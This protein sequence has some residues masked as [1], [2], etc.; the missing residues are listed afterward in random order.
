LNIAATFLRMRRWIGR[1]PT[2]EEVS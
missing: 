1:L 2:Y